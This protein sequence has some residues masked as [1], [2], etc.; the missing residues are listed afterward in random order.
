MLVHIDDIFKSSKTPWF[1]A[2]TFHEYSTI[3]S[4]VRPHVDLDRASVLDFGCGDLPIAAA[5]MALRHPGATVHGT[6]I[7][8][9]DPA[10]LQAVL[11]QESGLDT[12]ANLHVE[13]V[14]PNSLP[15]HLRN[16]D[17]IYSWSVFEHIP[18]ADITGNFRIV[19]ERLAPDGLF[20]FQI[21][22]L[23]FHNDGSHLSH[24]FPDEPWHHLVYS[25][26]ELQE[27]VLASPT[28]SKHSNW[29]QFMELNRL[30]AD[31]FMDAASD[32]GL[33]AVWHERRQQGEPPAQLLRSYSEE[34]LKT[35]EIRAL[36]R[37]K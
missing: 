27:K 10:R 16:L 2:R 31:D 35:I 9:T 25:L 19:R 29:Q 14:T 11:N 3:R 36:F 7:A 26:A 30:T 23:Y 22:G 15:E 5:S 18:A 8:G 32:A 1:R 37:G 33:S 21:G 13:T 4:L 28:A 6:D 20:F 17:L 34:A 12:P 24:L